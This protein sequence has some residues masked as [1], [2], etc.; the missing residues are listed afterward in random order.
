MRRSFHR[1]SL[2]LSWVASSAQMRGGRN[3]ASRTP[4]P[5]W[6]FFAGLVLLAA[7]CSGGD[8]AG[9]VDVSPRE[10]AKQCMAD[11]DANKDGALDAKELESCPGLMSALK[12]VDKNDDGRLSVDE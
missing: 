10:A 9:T 7:G 3:T 1:C 2:P 8:G 5:P 6:V 12:R 11:Y 4:V